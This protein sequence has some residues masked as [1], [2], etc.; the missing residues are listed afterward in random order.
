MLSNI[1]PR[2]TNIKLKQVDGLAIQNAGFHGTT[3]L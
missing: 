2:S 1:V 3:S